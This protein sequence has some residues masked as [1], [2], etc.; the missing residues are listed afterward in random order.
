MPERITRVF[1]AA[2]R[3]ATPTVGKTARQLGVARITVDVY[4]NRTPPSRA[5]A[6]R[7]VRW[8][9]Q[10]AARLLGYADQL[11]QAL[12]E[13]TDSTASVQHRRARKPR[14]RGG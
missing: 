3:A 9:R 1:R 10:H 14:G 12:G 5:M 6:E 2:L 11:E 13:E 7:L 8:L 4:L